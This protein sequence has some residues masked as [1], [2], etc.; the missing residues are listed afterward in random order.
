MHTAREPQ[1]DGVG[2]MQRALSD[3]GSLP[4]SDV[5]PE[6]WDDDSPEKLRTVPELDIHAIG[7]TWAAF[8]LP[9]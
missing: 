1:H 3:S 2:K 7:E 9:A 5:E 6:D 4:V 8:P